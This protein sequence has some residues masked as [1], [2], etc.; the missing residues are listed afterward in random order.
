MAPPNV[1]SVCRRDESVVVDRGRFQDLLIALLAKQVCDLHAQLAQQ[2]VRAALIAAA[3]D[4]E[5]TYT[6]NTAT[7]TVTRVGP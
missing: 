1:L 4:P 7:S 6:L 5:A 2:G 3:L